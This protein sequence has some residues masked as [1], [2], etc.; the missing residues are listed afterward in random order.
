MLNANLARLIKSLTKI[1]SFAKIN[2]I[3]QPTMTGTTSPALTASQM[4]TSTI[5]LRHVSPAQK[6]AVLAS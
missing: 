6:S 3:Q 2:A 4:S 5:F 1:T